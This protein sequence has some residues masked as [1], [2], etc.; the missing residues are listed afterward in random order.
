[1]KT[2][3]RFHLSAIVALLAMSTIVVTSTAFSYSGKTN[4]SVARTEVTLSPSETVSVNP[5]SVY[6]L[7]DELPVYPGGDITLMS[8]IAKI[9]VYPAEAKKNN[10]Q[11]KVVVR[12]IVGKDCKVSDVEVIKSVN[13]QL[14]AE[15]VRV[16]KTLKFEK[17]G[18][19]GGV[20]V[21]V[22]YMIPIQFALK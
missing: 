1:M 17:P 14:D 21:A 19:K 3:K 2:R 15:A 10:I 11:G 6:V 4:G 9:T 12:L 13:S 22:H 8:D 16:V 7:V 20:P 18:I 5:D